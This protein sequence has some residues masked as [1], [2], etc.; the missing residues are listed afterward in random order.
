MDKNEVISAIKNLTLGDLAVLFGSG[1]KE[2]SSQSV[3][4][5]KEELMSTKQILDKDD[6]MKLLN[7]A[8]FIGIDKEP[9]AWCQIVAE[10]E[11]QSKRT[12][13]LVKNEIR[14]EPLSQWFV[15]RKT[16]KFIECP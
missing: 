11:K 8:Y 9:S 15:E 5:T 3:C 4:V 10:N 6:I 7:I 12:Y 2:D 13:E 1:Q 14:Q 16:E